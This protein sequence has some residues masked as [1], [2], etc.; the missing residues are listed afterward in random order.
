MTTKV[1]EIQKKHQTGRGAPW[2]EIELDAWLNIRGLWKNR[3]L[4]ALKYQRRARVE[5]ER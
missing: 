4:D 5:A 3:K 1:L 2:R